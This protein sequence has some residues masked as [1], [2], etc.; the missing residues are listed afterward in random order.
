MFR[1]IP[2]V[3]P[4]Q[5]AVRWEELVFPHLLELPEGDSNRKGLV[6]QATQL[7]QASEHNLDQVTQ[8]HKKQKLKHNTMGPG[9]KLYLAR[10]EGPLYLS[11]AIFT[12]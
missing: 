12:A 7:T 5:V 2:V 10:S 1:R 4:D 8:G 3:E 6:S 11:R 9:L